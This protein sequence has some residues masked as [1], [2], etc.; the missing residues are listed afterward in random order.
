M[1]DALLH[2]AKPIE[3]RVNDLE[4]DFVARNKRSETLTRW[5][6]AVM[7]TLIPTLLTGIVVMVN[8]YSQVQRIDGYGTTYGRALEQ[9]WD[10]RIDVI[11]ESVL[12]LQ[13]AQEKHHAIPETQQPR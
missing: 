13:L 7:A 4:A 8:L 3:D 10:R 11:E 12:R 6:I 5:A 1:M 9:A 2:R